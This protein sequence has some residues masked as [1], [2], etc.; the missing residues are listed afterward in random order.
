MKK[1]FILL[2][3]IVITGIFI[4]GC[5]MDSVTYCPYCGSMNISPVADQPGVYQC[6]RPECGKKFGAKEIKPEPK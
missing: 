1:S 4:A 6:G 3:L 5:A 2:L